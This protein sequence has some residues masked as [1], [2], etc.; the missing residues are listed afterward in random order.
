M[1]REVRLRTYAKINWVLELLG[2]RRDGYHEIRTVTHT[3]SLWDEITVAPAPDGIV[4]TVD[5]DWPAPEGPDNLC[6]QAAAAFRQACGRPEGV[7]I[8]LTKHIPSGSGLGGGSSDCVATLAGLAALTQIRDPALVPRLAVE[9]GSDTALFVHGG[10]ALCSGRGEQITHIPCPRTYHLVIARPECSVSTAEAYQLIRPDHF[11]DGARALE[12][13]SLLEAGAQPQELARR[14]FNAF[15]AP[16]HERVPAVAALKAAMQQ[17]GALGAAM[18]G[19]GSAVFAVVTDRAA[20]QTL[21]ARLRN[22][23]YWAVPVHT[24]PHGHEFI[25]EHT[26]V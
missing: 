11:S 2:R 16:V 14:L 15:E 24:V 9:L 13:A 21:C 23:G 7:R 20:A 26:D 10:V 18:S 3:V 25:Q 22:C 6:W 1:S 19:S 17:P 12:M 8:N 4:V 5:G